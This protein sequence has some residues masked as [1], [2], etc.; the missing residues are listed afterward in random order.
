[1]DNRQTM[2]LDKRVTKLT[3]K[4]PQP[5]VDSPGQNTHST[6][7]KASNGVLHTGTIQIHFPHID[8][9]PNSHASPTYFCLVLFA[10]RF[11]AMK[12]I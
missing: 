6:G 4:Q 9:Y 7:H 2:N 1:M 3:K 10:S 8:P 11:F 5:Q 12:Y